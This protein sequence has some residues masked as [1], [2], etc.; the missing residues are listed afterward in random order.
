[1]PLPAIVHWDGYHWVVLRQVTGRHVK[2]VDPAL[3]HRTL[4]REAFTEKWSGYA[5]LFDYTPALEQ[6]PESGR[7]TDCARCRCPSAT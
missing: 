2:V 5:A 3:G 6:A 1:M 4:T 7:V